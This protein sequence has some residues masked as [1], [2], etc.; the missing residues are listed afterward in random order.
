MLVI[1][2][3]KGKKMGDLTKRQNEIIQTS[4]KLISDKGIQNFTTKSL[5]SL[6]GISEPAIYRHF[7]SKREILLTILLQI[8]ERSNELP[9]GKSSLDQIENMFIRQSSQFIANPALAAIIFSEEIFQND[10]E[11]SDLV[12]SMM[13]ERHNIILSIIKNEQMAGKVRNDIS[14]EQ[15]T[16]IIM[17]TLRLIISR[18]KLNSYKFDLKIEIRKSWLAI[19]AILIN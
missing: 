15:L 16:I 18:W 13:N 5:A 2:N 9:D 6:L 11:M 12:I 1:T 8:K 4:I 19:S 10:K 17:G 7:S 14:A 3:V